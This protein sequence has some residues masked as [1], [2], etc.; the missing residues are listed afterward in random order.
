[1]KT[2]LVIALAVTSLIA[3]AQTYQW[4]D[5]NG[6]TVISD[7]PPPG[8]AKTSKTIGGAP[9]APVVASAEK[10]NDAPKTMA[11][12]ELEFKKRQQEAKEKA[13]KESKEK[14]AETEKAANCE[15]ARRNLAALESNQ[16]LAQIDEQGRR[17]A[18]DNS[19]REQEMER[20]RK[21]MADTCK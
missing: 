21:F 11:D 16:P 2:A 18:M 9:T 10:S 4:K 1:M 7:T 14:A 20:A 13:D 19:Q 3:Q 6:R 5:T 12:K 17:Q 8:S 15:R